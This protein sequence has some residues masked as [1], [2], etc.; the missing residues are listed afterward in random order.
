MSGNG[1]VQQ[2]LRRADDR[3]CRMALIW[4]SEGKMK[5][6]RPNTNW[7]WTAETE[8]RLLDW[9]SWRQTGCRQ[10]QLH[11]T[12]RSGM[13][14]LQSYVSTGM[15]NKVKLVQPL[16]T[17][18]CPICY[19]GPKI[20]VLSTNPWQ[21]QPYLIIVRLDEMRFETK[22]KY[23]WWTLRKTGLA[24]KRHITDLARRDHRD[25]QQL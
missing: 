18:F 9:T 25:C 13:T 7:R 11:M 3:Y 2:I 15:K 23:D 14:A 12:D 1:L 16:V 8:R 20:M 17:C 19:S 6:G 10:Q 5:W 4:A 22:Q 24:I 21:L